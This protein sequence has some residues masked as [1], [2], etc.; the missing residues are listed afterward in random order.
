MK[1]GSG[2]ILLLGLMGAD[3]CGGYGTNPS[4]SIAEQYEVGAVWSILNLVETLL[5]KKAN[6]PN[7]DITRRGSVYHLYVQPDAGSKHVSS[8]VSGGRANNGD[9]FGAEEAR[10]ARIPAVGPM[11]GKP[12]GTTSRTL[13]ISSRIVNEVVGVTL[14]FGNSKACFLKAKYMHIVWLQR[15]LQHFLSTKQP[16]TCPTASG[17][18]LVRIFECQGVES[19]TV[20]TKSDRSSWE[21]RLWRRTAA[22]VLEALG[23]ID[24]AKL[25]PRR[26]TVWGSQNVLAV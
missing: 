25:Q 7:G 20:E 19:D 10:A 4:V 5:P 6:V 15:T 12:Q 16:K 14:L 18:G 23:D 1:E 2:F 13:I 21:R 26:H 22:P 9:L 11:F 8:E 17:S 24:K 3:R